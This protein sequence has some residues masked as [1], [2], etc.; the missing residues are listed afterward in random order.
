MMDIRGYPDSPFNVEAR[1]PAIKAPIN[2]AA[3]GGKGEKIDELESHGIRDSTDQPR[4][5]S[6]PDRTV[7]HHGKSK[8]ATEAG[9]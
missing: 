7:E 4:C 6:K 9:Q 8:D 3:A 1:I 5:C 2:A